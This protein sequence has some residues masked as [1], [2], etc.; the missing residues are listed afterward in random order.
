MKNQLLIALIPLLVS[1]GAGG[2]KTA[3]ETDLTRAEYV[4][5]RNVVDTMHLRERPFHREIVSNGRLRAIRKSDLRFTL[6]G[7]LAAVEAVNGRRV[8]AGAV[9]ARLDTT[10]SHL[11]LLQAEQQA[12]QAYYELVDN[13]IGFGQGADTAAVPKEVLETA[14][15]RAGYQTAQGNLILARRE[16]EQSTLRAP[17]AG[18]VAGLSLKTYEQVSGAEVFCTLIDDGV[19]EVEFN[20]L[21]SEI[22]MV[23]TGQRLRV[24]PFNYPDQVYE[25]SISQINP[26]VD[27]RGQIA[28]RAEVANRG[29]GLMEGMNVRVT[30]EEALDRQLTVPK[31]AVVIRDNEE[32][33]F[34]VGPE[35]KAMWT[36]VEVLMSNSTDHVVT[37]NT[38][39]GAELN[40]GDAI[41]TSGN[42]N[43]GD[44]STVEV[45]K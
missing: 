2:R 38:E 9:I 12:R 41:I 40:P 10:A 26:V 1:C 16:L 22:P 5:E 36:Y 31:S 44:G 32:V 20:L 34:R 29:E 7:Q 28:L 33:L 17:F 19:F 11:R 23:R 4:P 30:I 35:G 25:G 13:L 21:E 15:V 45:R 8:A 24:S 39:R 3:E 6:S 43:L 18:K 27:E 37:A 42:L 14:S